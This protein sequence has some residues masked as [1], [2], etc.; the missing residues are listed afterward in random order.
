MA[1]NMTGGGGTHIKVLNIPPPPPVWS[2]LLWAHFE[3]KLEGGGGGWIIT[4]EMV[5]VC[6]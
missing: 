1:V 5:S 2:R 3:V 6:T 4:I